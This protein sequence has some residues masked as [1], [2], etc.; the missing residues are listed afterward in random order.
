MIIKGFDGHT[1]KLPIGI[2]DLDDVLLATH[3]RV[4]PQ[5]MEG[6]LDS[7]FDTDPSL[8]VKFRAT[9]EEFPAN[10]EAHRPETEGADPSERSFGLAVPW[11]T[12]CQS[13]WRNN[14]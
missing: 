6:Q 14:P 2:L 7:T 10:L 11:T 13:Y 8:D 1:T 3:W 12:V 9:N 4:T 5:V